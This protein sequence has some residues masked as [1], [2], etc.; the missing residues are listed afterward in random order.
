MSIILP[1]LNH[2]FISPVPV[3]DPDFLVFHTPMT[4]PQQRKE[5]L[6]IINQI[7]KK[8]RHSSRAGIPCLH[9]DTIKINLINKEDTFAS[10]RSGSTCYKNKNI[11]GSL[12]L[13]F[14]K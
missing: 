2:S 13:D 7:R 11:I 12:V 8:S 4:L 9:C 14:S 6:Y 10:F 3:P 1:N 5:D